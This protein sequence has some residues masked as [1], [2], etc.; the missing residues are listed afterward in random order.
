MLQHIQGA[1]HQKS[2][3]PR[4]GLVGGEE[5]GEGEGE[6]SENYRSDSRVNRESAAHLDE[7]F[8]RSFL[9]GELCLRGVC[10]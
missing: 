8:I 10:K 7:G 2:A 9:S 4:P 6:G 3:P 5:E 1:K